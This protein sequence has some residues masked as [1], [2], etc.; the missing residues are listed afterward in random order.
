MRTILPDSMRITKGS[1]EVV[2]QRWTCNAIDTRKRT[3]SQTMTQTALHGQLKIKNNKFVG[4][5]HAKAKL[6]P[7]LEHMR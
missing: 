7:V 5:K 3:D 1:S 6:L 2:I 4:R